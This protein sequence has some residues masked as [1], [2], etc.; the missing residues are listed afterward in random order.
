[1]ADVN[2]PTS[3][4]SSVKDILLSKN[5]WI[6]MILGIILI[7]I[8]AV[9]KLDWSLALAIVITIVFICIEFTDYILA[10]VIVGILT[11]VSYFIFIGVNTRTIPND[12]D[13]QNPSGETIADKTHRAKEK[14]DE[15]HAKLLNKI[16][17]SNTAAQSTISEFITK[18][19]NVANAVNS[20]TTNDIRSYLITE[21]TA[22]QRLLEAYN[23]Q[24]GETM[25]TTNECLKDLPALYNVQKSVLDGGL[26]ITELKPIMEN[27]IITPLRKNVKPSEDI[28][29]QLSE[30][31]IYVKDA[32]IDARTTDTN[33]TTVKT[34]VATN[35]NAHISTLN[36]YKSTLANT[37]AAIQ[38]CVDLVGVAAKD[39]VLNENVGDPEYAG[40]DKKGSS[41]SS[42]NVDNITMG[43]K[44]SL[45]IV[46]TFT[47]SI[48][49]IIVIVTTISNL[50]KNMIKQEVKTQKGAEEA[51]KIDAYTNEEWDK[52]FNSA[53]AIGSGFIKQIFSV[54]AKFSKWNGSIMMLL[55]VLW[56]LTSYMYF[57]TTTTV[58]NLIQNIFPVYLIQQTNN[59]ATVFYFGII[60]LLFLAL[61]V[62]LPFLQKFDPTIKSNF[63]DFI[64]SIQIWQWE[65]PTGFG[66]NRKSEFANDNIFKVIFRGVLNVI[67]AV[68]WFIINVVKF[69][70]I[71]LIWLIT[72]PIHKV[73]TIIYDWMYNN[74]TNTNNTNNTTN[75]NTNNKNGQQ[76]GGNTAASS[77]PNYTVKEV[78]DK[79]MKDITNITKS[80]IP[81]KENK[82]QWWSVNKMS[83]FS[84]TNGG[85]N[86]G[87]ND[88]K[89]GNKQDNSDKS[90]DP[91]DSVGFMKKMLDMLGVFGLLLFAVC[92]IS[93]GIFS[94]MESGYANIAMT[95]VGGIVGIIAL[96]IMVMF[97]KRKVDEDKSG[98][99]ADMDKPAAKEDGTG[100][101]LLK[102][103]WSVI[104][105]IPCLLIGA[106]DSLKTEWQLTTGPIWILLCLEILL[107]ALIFIMPYVANKITESGS[108][109]V[110]PGVKP[111]DSE[112]KVS[113]LDESGVFIFHN[114]P[115]SDKNNT[116]MKKRYSYSFSSWFYLHGTASKDK[117]VSVL[118]VGG[119]PKIEYNNATNNLRF[120]V[121]MDRI[122]ADGANKITENRVIYETNPIPNKK[123]YSK[124]SNGNQR[125][126]D[127][128][129]NFGY[130]DKNTNEIKSDNPKTPVLRD[131]SQYRLIT[132]LDEEVMSG[133]FKPALYIPMQ[134]WFNVVVNYDGTTMDIFINGEL[135]SSSRNIIPNIRSNAIITGAPKGVKGEICNVAFYN[136]VLK[137]DEIK[138]LYAT[139]KSMDPPSFHVD[140]TEQKILEGP[141]IKY[142]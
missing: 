77:S 66:T 120:T 58:Q 130:I 96:T 123:V 8:S 80:Y 24:S 70:G 141:K 18:V 136:K 82:T 17:A 103:L 50:L 67:W 100:K 92:V 88:G 65:G 131:E 21:I 28:K 69:V 109:P 104:K 46:S 127:I 39:P 60:F 29:T 125:I 140:T 35:M 64:R 99:F 98:I 6:G 38:K 7:I 44:K 116:Q 41:S 94:L 62:F 72:W 68:L 74:N 16:Q 51:K 20:K 111:L 132:T 27:A 133:A 106:L 110:L 91:N 13:Q 40:K 73:F 10:P 12:D 47:V 43:G 31:V 55:A 128:N 54:F 61:V 4:T 142:S 121:N 81:T 33:L 118:D 22:I 75:N 83:V 52:Y 76:K 57:T 56:T 126:V 26:L 87:K 1:M 112:Y 90:F 9:F 95:I 78:F 37:S 129:G 134:K 23:I 117:F 25:S 135:V 34:K 49:I 93:V 3:D 97:I 102:L 107:I 59:V 2:T 63:T 119:V 89:N 137:G 114:S 48:G 45:D 122:T 32:T 14:L 84:D 30:L 115:V 11:L 79:L 42:D 19:T 139:F 138:W 85:E 15:L 105:Y 86:D 113:S 124:D 36:A 71:G 5:V 53:D 108:K 101:L